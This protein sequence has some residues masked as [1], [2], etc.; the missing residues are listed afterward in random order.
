M[1]KYAIWLRIISHITFCLS[2]LIRRTAE[3]IYNLNAGEL[4]SALEAYSNSRRGSQLSRKASI[5]PYEGSEMIVPIM[6]HSNAGTLRREHHQLDGRSYPPPPPHH[7]HHCCT[8]DKASYSTMGRGSSY[9]T[10]YSEIEWMF[11]MVTWYLSNNFVE[12][13]SFGLIYVVYP[14]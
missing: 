3:K 13:M 12:K 5:I 9:H 4:T 6:M 14:T 1:F 7:H 2:F 10:K 11:C 8:C